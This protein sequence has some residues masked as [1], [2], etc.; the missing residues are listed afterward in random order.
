MIWLLTS[1]QVLT[2]SLVLVIIIAELENQTEAAVVFSRGPARNGGR[3]V[4]RHASYRNNKM[5]WYCRSSN[6]R[7]FENGPCR[8]SGKE[9]QRYGYES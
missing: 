2:L 1:K 5:P 4:R 7:S 3:N 6:R 8:R 9:R